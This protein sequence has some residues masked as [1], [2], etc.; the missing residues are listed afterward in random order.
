M[1][2]ASSTSRSLGPRGS[3]PTEEASGFTSAPPAA[4]TASKTPAALDVDP[5]KVRRTHSRRLDRPGQMNYRV[6]SL[7]D[8]AQIGGE[9]VCLDPAGLGSTQVGSRLASP[10][11]SSISWLSPSLN[12]TGAD[13]SRRARDDYLHLLF[14]PSRGLGFQLA[15]S[16]GEPLP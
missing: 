7:E 6:G 12:G 4:A 16:D 11:I 5:L 1:D 9:D 2:Q 14:S 13:I 10:T 3:T 15:R 8:R